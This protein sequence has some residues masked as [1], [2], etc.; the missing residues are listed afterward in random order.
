MTAA[1]HTAP[2]VSPSHAH[3][4]SAASRIWGIVRI[5]YLNRYTFVGIPLIILASAVVVSIAI[6]AM[7]GADSPMYGGAVQAPLWYFVGA[8]VQAMGLTFPFAQALTATR[9]EFFLGTALAALLAA[10]G[11]SLVVVLLG[12]LEQATNGYGVNGYISRLPWLWEQGGAVAGLLYLSFT[13]L[14]FFVGFW[15]ATLYRRGGALV[16]TLAAIGLG[17]LVVGTLFVITRFELW[18]DVVRVFAEAGPLG[19]TG[20]LCVLVALAALAGWLTLRRSTP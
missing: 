16:V 5:Q 6:Y 8:G 19:V 3:T 18:G 20:V 11:L 10:S 2:A 4:P 17:V 9:R 15:M 13:L 14:V 1:A 7:I 12:Y